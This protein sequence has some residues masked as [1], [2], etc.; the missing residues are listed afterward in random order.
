MH[1]D[2]ELLGGFNQRT[3][4][5]AACA[6][7][8]LHDAGNTV[9]AEMLNERFVLNAIL[10]GEVEG[11]TCTV[12]DV[13]QKVDVTQTAA[14]FDHV[15][16]H[17]F[18]RVFNAFFFLQRRT[19]NGKSAAVDGRVAAVSGHFFKQHDGSA[20]FFGFQG[21]GQSGKSAANDDDVSNFVEFLFGLR[22]CEC[23]TSESRGCAGCR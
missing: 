5:A 19:G 7:N 16:E 15:L 14:G 20:F 23:E 3:S 8:G 18:G 9:T 1:I 6:F 12:N 10:H 11:R 21:C 13:L 4:D 17:E 22:S 2:A